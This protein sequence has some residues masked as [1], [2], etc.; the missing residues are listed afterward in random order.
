MNAS[1]QMKKNFKT[2]G[3]EDFKTDISYK[4]NLNVDY[5]VTICETLTD[6]EI[7]LKQ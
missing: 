4:V 5:D 7:L 6:R 2:D 1:T 3:W